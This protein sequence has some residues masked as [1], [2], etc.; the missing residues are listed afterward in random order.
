MKC[1]RCHGSGVDDP[2]LVKPR[3][4]PDCTLGESDTCRFIGGPSGGQTLTLS[5]QPREIVMFEESDIELF[6][7]LGRL[8]T[9]RAKPRYHLYTRSRHGDYYWTGPA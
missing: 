8:G 7:P 5:S 6:P 2:S 3:R 4:C 9:D 1:K